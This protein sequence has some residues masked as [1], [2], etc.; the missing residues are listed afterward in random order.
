MIYSCLSNMSL[1]GSSSSSYGNRKHYSLSGS[2]KISGLSALIVSSNKS[3]ICVIYF[4]FVYSRSDSV[5]DA[6]LT[7]V[8][9]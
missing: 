4:R 9:N 2:K 5:I 8:A 1:V 6:F 7:K 3:K